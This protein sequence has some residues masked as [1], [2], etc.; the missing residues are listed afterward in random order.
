MKNNYKSALINGVPAYA[1]TFSLFS[2][3]F[4]LFFYLFCAAFFA[5][6]F[7]YSVFT[8]VPQKQDIRQ[9]Y[10]KKFSSV[11]HR[12]SALTSIDFF[13]NLETSNAKP[14]NT[15]VVMKNDG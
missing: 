7:L 10:Q 13:T 15:K 9:E 3:I 2:L 11:S 8:R 4:F 12:F 6:A 14:H 1:H 5:L